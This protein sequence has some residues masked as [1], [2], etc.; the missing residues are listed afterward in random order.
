[1]GY[2]QN[3]MDKVVTV[4][5]GNFSD[6]ILEFDVEQTSECRKKPALVTMGRYLV[7]VELKKPVATRN[8]ANMKFLCDVIV[9]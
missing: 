5:Y 3:T 9:C 6:K 8:N 7:L 1:M 4:R 2:K